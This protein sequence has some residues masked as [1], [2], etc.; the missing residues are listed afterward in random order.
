LLSL[1]LEYLTLSPW[2]GM[3]RYCHQIVK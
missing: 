2:F 1:V 3:R